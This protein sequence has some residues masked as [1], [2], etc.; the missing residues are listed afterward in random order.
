MVELS[1]P[2]VTTFIA[3]LIAMVLIGVWVYNRTKTLSDFAL[4]GRSLNAPTAALS[5]QA[6]DMSGW[7]LMGLPAA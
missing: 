5:A 4:G 7:L 6:S 1:G 2:I 3:Y